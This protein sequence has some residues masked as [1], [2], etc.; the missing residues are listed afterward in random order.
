MVRG[1]TLCCKKNL[2]PFGAHLIPIFREEAGLKHK[3]NQNF[4]FTLEK[5]LLNK[6][7]VFLHKNNSF[8]GIWAIKLIFR[9]VLAQKT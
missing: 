6:K 8:W 7:V 4:N 9:G 3:K 2:G 1:L 5:S